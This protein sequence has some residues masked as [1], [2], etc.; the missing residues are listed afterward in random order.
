MGRRQPA[1]RPTI[2]QD[3]VFLNH[4]VQNQLGRWLASLTRA[5][6]LPNRVARQT[7]FVK[8]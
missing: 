4:R 5:H 8:R 7:P 2:A 6:M 3:G 1:Q